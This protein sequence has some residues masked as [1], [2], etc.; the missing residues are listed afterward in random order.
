[1]R[2]TRPSAARDQAC[3]VILGGPLVGAAGLKT[4]GMIVSIVAWLAAP[5]VQGAVI[6]WEVAVGLALITNRTPGLTWLAAVVTFAGFAAVGGW[7][8]AAGVAC[9]SA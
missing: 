5:A 3:A 7:L 1:M 9:A 6:A 2:T 8:G 4:H